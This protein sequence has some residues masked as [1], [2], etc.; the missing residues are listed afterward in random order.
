METDDRWTAHMKTMC[1]VLW[2]C[3][4]NSPADAQRRA[5]MG[6]CVCSAASM[7]HHS[8]W[9]LQGPVGRHCRVLHLA[10]HLQHIRGATNPSPTARTFQRAPAPANN[11]SSGF[12]TPRSWHAD[13]FGWN[14]ASPTSARL[15]GKRFVCVSVWGACVSV[16]SLERLIRGG[17]EESAR[18]KSPWALSPVLTP[19]NLSLSS[20]TFTHSTS[21]DTRYPAALQ[22]A[23]EN[24]LLRWLSAGGKPRSLQRP[25]GLHHVQTHGTISDGI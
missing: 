13:T 11:T 9:Q 7:L 17:V 25:E 1:S 23:E 10:E 24:P 4:R 18:V 22:R 15:G 8:T 21:I 6:V 14:V 20:L 19:L 12:S 5:M 2:W 16:A 3:H